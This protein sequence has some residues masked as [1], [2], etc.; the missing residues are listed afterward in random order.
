MSEVEQLKREIERLTAERGE[1]ACAAVESA[2]AH[3]NAVSMVRE[4]RTRL[5]AA[6]EEAYARPCVFNS[7]HG[8]MRRES[9]DAFRWMRGLARGESVDGVKM[10]ATRGL[11]ALADRPSGYIVSYALGPPDDR[12]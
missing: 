2:F 8:S 5:R 4:A 3:W 10:S 12:F 11:Y 6:L 1:K 9:I 7:R